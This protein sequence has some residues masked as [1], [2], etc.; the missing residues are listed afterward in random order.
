MTIE[1]WKDILGFEGIYKISDKG[2]VKRLPG[3]IVCK[4]GVIKK[5]KETILRPQKYSNGYLFYNLSVK[6]SNKCLNA[7][8]LVAKAFLPNESNKREVNH[9][10]EDKTDNRVENLQWVTHKENIN[11]GTAIARRVQNSNFKGSNNP[12][13]GNIGKLNPRSKPLIQYDLDGNAIKEFDS[14]AS[15]N[16]ELGFDLSSLYAVLN[17]RRPVYKNFHWKYKS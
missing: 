7:H 8:R 9:I 2:R 1:V 5:L 16:R 4:N 17:N 13:F 11:H 12:M 6:G 10:N 3:K 15:V 14:V